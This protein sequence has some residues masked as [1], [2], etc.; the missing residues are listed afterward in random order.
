[1]FA[2]PENVQFYEN[3]EYSQLWPGKEDSVSVK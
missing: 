2:S 3:D 1:M